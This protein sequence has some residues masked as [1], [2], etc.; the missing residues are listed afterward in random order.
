MKNE[1]K[2]IALQVVETDVPDF[3]I[4]ILGGEIENTFT[5]SASN[6]KL[7]FGLSKEIK[8]YLVNCSGLLFELFV[9]D[10]KLSFSYSHVCFSSD[11][12]TL[13]AEKS[14]EKLYPVFVRN[15]YETPTYFIKDLNN[16]LF[17]IKHTI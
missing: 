12:A 6:S 1:L 10:Q 15:N 7:I 16:N 4:N 14:N 9:N 2:H 3:Y 17:E 13:I 8:V 5:L 11:K